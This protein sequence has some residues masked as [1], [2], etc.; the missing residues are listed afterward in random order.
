MKK[1]LLIMFL[2]ALLLSG[3]TVQMGQTFIDPWYVYIGDVGGGHLAV[4]HTPF[5]EWSK[6]SADTTDHALIEAWK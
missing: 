2:A 3:C 1:L 4:L 6:V 5:F